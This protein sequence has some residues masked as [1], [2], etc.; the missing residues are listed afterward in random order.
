M[1]GRLAIY[2]LHERFRSDMALN[3]LSESSIYTPFQSPLLKTRGAYGNQLIF[4][5][6]TP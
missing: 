5:Y 4:S 1:L 2:D 6:R 3:S